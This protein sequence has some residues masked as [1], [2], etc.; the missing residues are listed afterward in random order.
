MKGF[1]VSAFMLMGSLSMAQSSKPLTFQAPARVIKNDSIVTGARTNGKPIAGIL[2]ATTVEPFRGVP[3]AGQKSYFGDKTEYVNGFVRKYLGTHNR[4][5]STVETRA[6]N[7]FSL[8][9]NILERNHIPSELK[10]LAVIESALNNQAVS[11]V[12][13]VGPWQLMA[14]TAQLMGLRVNGKHDE[15]KDWYKS[16]HAA[17]KYLNFLYGQLNDWLL[18]VAAYNSGPTPVLRAIDRTGSHNFWDIKKYLPRET[19][20]HV[21]A[22]VA[23]ASIFEKMKDYIAQ[24]SLPDDFKFGNEEPGQAIVKV[25]PPKPQFTQEELEHM[26]IV[27]IHEPLNEDL[28][29]SELGIDKNLFDKWNPDYELFILDT[30]SEDFFRLRIPKD[31]LD[32]FVA[33]KDFLSKKS[34]QIYSA[35]VM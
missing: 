20:G 17:A 9:E 30:Y 35:Q 8:I 34:Q 25:A 2:P 21:L 14:S 10:Y 6:R 33:E 24:G 13:A 27:R 7:K 31:K 16:T 1:F 3:L 28:L 18:V 32:K 12:G 11:P 15:R 22:F 19:Q 23:T 26:A 29:C 4:T 5:L